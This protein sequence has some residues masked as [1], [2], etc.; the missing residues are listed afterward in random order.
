MKRIVFALFAALIASS[1]T[2]SI[3]QRDFKVGQRW[4]YEARPRDPESTVLIVKLRE[5]DHLGKPNT[6]LFVVV[7]HVCITK[8]CNEGRSQYS[9][10]IS[11]DALRQSVTNFLNTENID[12]NY[13][14]KYRSPDGLTEDDLMVFE[15][16][17]AQVV[18]RFGKTRRHQYE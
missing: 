12:S 14:Q 3:T 18:D 6:A 17:L 11:E 16:P 15:V 13:L 1:C 2:S 5:S 10:V 9:F 7:D 4:A 8:E